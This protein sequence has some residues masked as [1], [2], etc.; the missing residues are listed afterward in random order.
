M[1]YCAISPIFKRKSDYSTSSVLG[2][3]T[4]KVA[5]WALVRKQAEDGKTLTKPPEG[6]L[7]AVELPPSAFQVC[8]NLLLPPCSVVYTYTYTRHI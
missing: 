1:I 8:A 3:Y 2:L 4:V 7:T 6:K 5:W